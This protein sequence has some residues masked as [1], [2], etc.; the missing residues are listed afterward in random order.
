MQPPRWSH[1]LCSDKLEFIARA[2]SCRCVN[3]RQPSSTADGTANAF[4]V[5]LKYR[6][7]RSYEESELN[8]APSLT[9]VAGEECSEGSNKEGPSTGLTELHPS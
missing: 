5:I 2:P 9:A 6:A 7:Q 3:G 8:S 4:D 1:A